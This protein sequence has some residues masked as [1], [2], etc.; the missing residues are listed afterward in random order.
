MLAQKFLLELVRDDLACRAVG[1]ESVPSSVVLLNL[2]PL[3]AY[4]ARR[5]DIRQ[6]YITNCGRLVPCK[7]G[8]YR[9][10]EFS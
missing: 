10:R 9:F 5:Y 1:I 2:I 6:V 4:V 3:D 8:V 7:H